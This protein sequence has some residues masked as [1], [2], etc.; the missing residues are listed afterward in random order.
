[1]RNRPNPRKPVAFRLDDP[2]VILAMPRAEA[3]AEVPRPSADTAAIVA[4]E[5]PAALPLL[6][7]PAVVRRGIPLGALFW[8]ATGGLVALGFGLAATRLIEDLF[9]RAEWLGW[10]GSGL[11][12]VSL[13]T[14]TVIAARE[15]I[16]LA[17]LSTVEKIQ[18]RAA[19]ALA[20]DDRNE[21]TAVVRELIRLLRF[22]P[23]LARARAAT[24]AHLDEI[25]DG[26]DLI[27]L[28]ERQLLGP[29]DLEARR[30]V[31]TAAKRVSLVTA[32]SP[33]AALDLIFVFVTALTLVRQLSDLYG[34]RPGML[35]LVRLFRHVIAHLAVTGSLA[36]TDGL[37]QQILGH[38]VAAKLSAKLGE[39]VLNGLLTA[40][41][42]LAAIEVARPLPF[43]ALKPPVLADLAAGLVKMRTPQVEGDP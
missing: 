30:R 17:R 29:L 1:M 14:L 37:I 13:A 25:I 27:R 31:A 3:E 35:G 34:S 36:A 8:A 33:R 20:A 41:L 43:A 16:G 26:A 9:A 2:D 21:A 5:V 15:A 6:P 39:G 38:G 32:V 4:R 42:G 10:L 19:E 40:R 22:Q 12:V 23:R 28:A 11:G 18:A 7:A 24:R